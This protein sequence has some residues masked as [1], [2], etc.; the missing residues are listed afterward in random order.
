MRPFLSFT[1]ERLERVVT[2]SEGD[3][4]KLRDILEE[5]KYRSTARAG[6][7]RERVEETLKTA[8]PKYQAQQN[9]NGPRGSSSSTKG[10]NGARPNSALRPTDEQLECIRIFGN[11]SS[12][13]VNAFAGSG[14][15]TTLRLLA[16]STQDS[17]IYLAFNR[18]AKNEARDKFPR[19][20]SCFTTHGLAFRAMAGS[21]PNEKLT[22]VMNVNELAESLNLR[23]VKL[24][25]D[26][27]LKA[28]SFAYLIKE[29][30]RKF[31]Y[32]TAET[33]NEISVPRLNNHASMRDDAWAIL[34]KYVRQY[35]THTWSRMC[36]KADAI[37]LGH[38]GYLKLWAL[39]R[40]KIA[41]DFILFDEAQD[42][43]PVVLQ[44]IENQRG[45]S[46]ITYVGDRHQQIYEW[47]SAINAMEKIETQHECYLTKS[48]RFGSAIA[49]VAT[50]ILR[51]LGEEK[52]IIGNELVESRIKKMPEAS[53]VLSRT[54]AATISEL[55]SA[56]DKGR[57]PHLVGGTLELK[58]LVE[59]VLK[60]KAG[61][62]SE[63][64]ELFGFA[65][66]NEVLEFVR[67]GEGEHLAAFVNLVES[68]TEKQLLWALNRVVDEH[69]ADIVISTAHKA[70]GREWKDV[71]LS[72]GFIKSGGVSNG[73]HA[74]IPDLE[75]RL[76][77]VAMTRAREC[78]DVD[79]AS[80]SLFRQSRTAF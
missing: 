71:R 22:R 24:G 16:E 27:M 9:V 77:Y 13:K 68:R 32:S 33:M 47:R 54:N 67:S 30:V 14:K 3:L 58:T 29:T 31:S 64:P 20:V 65:D 41:S 25:P 63:A 61:E 26:R 11:S 38:D 69:E 51:H 42:T 6:K 12:L 8:A 5:L 46:K 73:K 49:D 34:E 36:D 2:D 53:A 79:P 74:K 70:K 28:R 44:V 52:R 59:G 39:S 55:V 21:Y 18:V 80:L 23:D 66:W 57:R 56:I 78:L 76:F 50:E 35:A 19:N 45:H 15:T 7:L 48:F 4:N 10:K 17:G 60:L 40:P 75:A 72:D 1:I 43:N 62:P 37:P